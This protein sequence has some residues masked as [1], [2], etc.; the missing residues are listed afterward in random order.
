MY[1]LRMP[2]PRLAMPA[3]LPAIAPC[4]DI[5][6]IPQVIEALGGR[7]VLGQKLDVLPDALAMWAY[8]GQIPTGWHLRLCAKLVAGGFAVFPEVFGFN[9]TSRDARA[10]GWLIARAGEA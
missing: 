9:R 10:L 6:S 8:Y 1:A 5:E 4:Q 3:Q 7:R 2:R